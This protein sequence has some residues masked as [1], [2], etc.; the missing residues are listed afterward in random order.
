MM[1]VLPAHSE[2]VIA[3]SNQSNNLQAGTWSVAWHVAGGSSFQSTARVGMQAVADARSG[4]RSNL[5]CLNV[6][7]GT[8]SCVNR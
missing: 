3:H 8:R 6:P 5:S 2:G 1:P 4:T 7:G